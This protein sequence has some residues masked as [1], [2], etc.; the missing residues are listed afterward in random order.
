MKFEVRLFL[1]MALAAFVL[2]SCN[3]ENFS[4]R[5][6]LDPTQVSQEF[7]DADFAT[8]A[9]RF[10]GD[11]T[12]AVYVM[13]N[14]PGSNNVLIFNRRPNGT[15]AGP[16][17]VATH[18][19]GSGGG[20]GS[21]GSIVTD[22]EYVYAVNAGSNTISVLRIVGK[23]L[24]F[25]D[26]TSSHGMMPISITVHGNVIYVVNAGGSGNISGFK[27]GLGGL[28]HI[29]FSDQPLSSSAAGPAQI[30]FNAAGDQ[31]VVTEKATNMITTYP[32]DGNGRAGV[33][34][35]F[36]SAGQTPFGFE[37]TPAG[38]LVVSE[39]FGG[40]TDASAVSSYNLGMDGSINLI[41]GPEATNQTAACWV[42][43]T[44]DG[45]FAYTTNTGSNSVT[46]YRIKDNGQLHLL[47]S[48]GITGMVGDGPID[49]DMSPNSIF[50]YVL[51]G[52]DNS[53]SVLSRR[54]NGQL[55]PV[56]TITGLPDAVVGMAVE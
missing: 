15:L 36:P 11:G 14:D 5:L 7:T 29:P 22:G 38:D 52:R 39:A 31:L 21:Q 41:D 51:N 8:S 4:D 17:K 33:G 24:K 18:G 48:D 44:S 13:D 3:K 45:Q 20:L 30:S 2:S 43:V 32:V 12:G 47:N 34:T 37:F 26:K 40:N 27:L 1:A 50:L 6:E 23:T 49:M 9:F 35:S 42:E 16:K 10:P 25:V 54:Y 53:I 46:G 56:E 19:Q 28:N 55:F